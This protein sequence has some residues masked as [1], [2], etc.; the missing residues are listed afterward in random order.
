[1]IITFGHL[2][3]G[4]TCKIISYRGRF[5]GN[6]ETIWKSGY[7]SFSRLNIIRKWRGKGN[8]L[9]WEDQR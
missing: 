2:V 5:R 8:I 1:M 6:F 7:P 9:Q 3:R 4:K